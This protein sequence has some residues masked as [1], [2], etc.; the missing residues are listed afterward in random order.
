MIDQLSVLRHYLY[1]RC[2]R[3]FRNRK[4]LEQYQQRKLKCHLR[5]VAAHSELYKNLSDLEEYPIADKEFMMEHFDQLNTVRIGRKEAE[6]FAVQAE[7]DRNFSPKLQGV[8]VGLSSGTSGKRGIFLVSDKEKNRWAGYI[9]A[10]FLD[11]GIL[12]YYSI[13]FFMRAD[14][15]LYQ[16]VSSKKIRFH[17]FDIYRSI[18][19]HREHLEEICP[20]VLVGQPSLL[21]QLAGELEQGKLNIRPRT[22]ISIAEVLDKEDED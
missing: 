21:L 7:R 8:T 17:F 6:A 19:E 5:Y 18:E 20:Q 15:N 13:A 1:Y 9:L 14:S 16:A 22:V 4:E 2:F 11:R 12:Q 10:K 3:H